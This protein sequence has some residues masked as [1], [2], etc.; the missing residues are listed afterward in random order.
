MTSQTRVFTGGYI[1][2]LIRS[3]AQGWAVRSVAKS[4]KT[5]CARCTKASDLSALDIDSPF[6]CSGLVIVG[7]ESRMGRCGGSPSLPDRVPASSFPSAPKLRSARPLEQLTL[8][9]LQL[10]DS[11]TGF[12]ARRNESI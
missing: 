11:M 4:M 2:E 6:V 3:Q 7:V 8:G 10:E 1:S 12:K 5:S 9:S